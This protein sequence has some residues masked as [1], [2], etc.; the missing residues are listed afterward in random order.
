MVLITCIS[1]T[2]EFQD[3]LPVTKQFYLQCCTKDVVP[4]GKQVLEEQITERMWQVV[5]SKANVRSNPSLLSCTHIHLIL[6]LS[7]KFIGIFH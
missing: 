6:I 5:S 7:K 3:T 1:T 2:N 4:L